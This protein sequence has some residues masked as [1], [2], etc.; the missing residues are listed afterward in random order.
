MVCHPHPSEILERS[1]LV[2]AEDTSV[3]GV[4]WLEGDVARRTA[5]KSG[6]VALQ[7]SAD[8]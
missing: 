1:D 8:G 5:G 3:A 4:A 7:P 2:L 6:A